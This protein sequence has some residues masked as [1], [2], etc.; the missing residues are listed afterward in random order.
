ME[1]RRVPVLC[2]E[3]QVPLER[4]AELAGRHP[5]LPLVL[6]GLGYR[7]QRILAPLLENFSNTFVSIGSNYSVHQGLEQLVRKVGA[8]RLLFGT[9]W[10]DADAAGAVTQLMYAGISEEEKA[11]IGSGNLERLIAGIRT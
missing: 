1:A 3:A 2:P 11:L 6:T 5:E 7:S 10:P 9:G 8:E 4:A